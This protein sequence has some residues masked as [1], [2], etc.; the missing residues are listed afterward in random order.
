MR[1]AHRPRRVLEA[2]D[3]ATIMLGC[4]IGVGATPAQAASSSTIC[5]G[6]KDCAREGKGSAGYASVYR[7][8]FWN[9]RAGHNCTNYVGYRLTHAGRVVNRPAGANDAGTWGRAARAAGIP[10]G[11]KPRVGSVAYWKA[12]YHGA[13]KG[14]HVAYVEKVNK[15]GSIVISEDHLGGTFVW[16]TLSKKSR[17]WPSGFIRFPRSNGSP[18]GKMLFAKPD[19]SGRIRFS[20]TAGEWDVPGGQHKYVVT[21][22]GPRG[23]AGVETFTFSS[24]YFR[25]ERLKTLQT[26]GRTT[27]YV[28]AL[29]TPGT[30][31]T[32]TLIGKRAVT[33][34]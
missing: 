18:S 27:I 11:K 25:F 33:I 23:A 3:A 20:G 16:R 34:R 22:G 17:S 29:N 13:S 15:N 4:V 12:G 30:R 32:D 31:G 14:G 2:L 10:V 6:F 7:Q 8:S 21:V 9:M 19:G 5:K 24:P 26:R 28:Y 1:I